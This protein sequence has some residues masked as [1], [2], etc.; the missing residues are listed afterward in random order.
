MHAHLTAP[1]PP[2]SAHP[3]ALTSDPSLPPQGIRSARASTFNIPVTGTMTADSEAS[4]A[5]QGLSRPGTPPPTTLPT[6]DVSAL[7][8]LHPTR[9]SSCLKAKP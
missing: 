2:R 6:T 8:A 3:S 5:Y 9:R 1:T 7:T 4:T